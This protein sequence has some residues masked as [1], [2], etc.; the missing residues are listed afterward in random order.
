MC[1]ELS[2]LSLSKLTIHINLLIISFILKHRCHVA[3]KFV[4]QLQL[5]WIQEQKSVSERE[6]KR[7]RGSKTRIRRVHICKKNL[8]TW[9]CIYNLLKEHFSFLPVTIKSFDC[10]CCCWS[11]FSTWCTQYIFFCWIWSNFNCYFHCLKVWIYVPD[12]VFQL[13]FALHTRRH[14]RCGSLFNHILM[15][16]TQRILLS[17]IYV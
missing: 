13:S 11:T 3:A 5:K 10:G 4:A 14:I 7:N 15:F 2:C 1:I 8:T 17:F 12:S 9:Q 16:S 6:R